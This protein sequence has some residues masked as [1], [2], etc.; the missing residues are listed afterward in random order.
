MCLRGD[1]SS[2]WQLRGMW[3]CVTQRQ[4]CEW[5]KN[6]AEEKKQQQKTNKK[7][8]TRSITSTWNFLYEQE[9]SVSLMESTDWPGEVYD[10]SGYTSPR[11]PPRCAVHDTERRPSAA[12]KPAVCC[13]VV[14]TQGRD[15][16]MQLA[17]CW[18]WCCWHP[19]LLLA[20]SASPVNLQWL[21]KVLQSFI[22]Y[23]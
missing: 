4:Q 22:L 8:K 21:V 7:K 14:D 9:A 23:K 17:G 10:S 18:W 13:C 1:T 16:L 5:G 3:L 19:P 20:R 11:P 15:G 12:Q 6:A 2:R